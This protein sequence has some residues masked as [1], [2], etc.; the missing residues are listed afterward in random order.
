MANL[1]R[2]K[3]SLRRREA[4]KSTTFLTQRAFK[5]RTV[6]EADAWI[7]KVSIL[8]HANTRAVSIGTG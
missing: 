6:K 4:M 7:T 5:D 1:K 3:R 8:Q 2:V